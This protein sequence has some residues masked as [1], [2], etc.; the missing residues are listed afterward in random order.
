MERSGVSPHDDDDDEKRRLQQSPSTSPKERPNLSSLEIPA[1][2]LETDDPTFTT[3]TRTKS[4]NSDSATREP[5][6]PRPNSATSALRNLLLPLPLPQ[7]SLS[8]T[9]RSK[10]RARPGGG[11]DDDDDAAEA[12]NTFL[13]I[14]APPLADPPHSVVSHL[15]SLFDS[16]FEVDCVHF[17]F[18]AEFLYPFFFLRKLDV[19]HHIRRSL[20]VPLDIK[21]A[22]LGRTDSGALFRVISAASPRST[23]PGAD[24]PS[25]ATW[26]DIAIHDEINAGEE[27]IPEEEAVCRICLVELA[28]GGDTLKLECSCKGELAL[29]H[30]ACA[31]KWF[32]IKGNRTC[33]VCKQ[34]VQN[35]PVTLLKIQN[36][37]TVRRRRRRPAR[38]QAEVPQNEIVRYS[39]AYKP[40]RR[41]VTKVMSFYMVWQ[42]VPVLVVVSMLAYFCFLEQML[43]SEFGPRALAMSLPFACVLGLLSS[44]IASNMVSRSYMWA[45]ASFQF[46]VVILF[47]HI[48]YAVLNLNA[49]MS[50]IL[51]S[52]TGLGMVVGMNSLIVECLRWRSMQRL[53]LASSHLQ[54]NG[55]MQLQQQQQQQRQQSVE[56][57]S[58]RHIDSSRQQEEVV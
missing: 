27:D 48:F 19:H 12:E 53:P 3:T 29:A 18:L 32:S 38:Q 54:V 47:A 31:V 37:R 11:D 30:Q 17:A 22:H 6:P 43:V 44:M 7:R 10:S 14:P 4:W 2:S 55:T 56:D 50:V 49:V 42:D 26:G 46:A 35:L 41:K 23:I 51:S 40:Q 5:L 9:F 33:D 13:L 1:R 57:S 28:E 52:L 16:Q 34:E 45:Y 8:L 39:S 15:F 58:V 24:F 21:P 36:P 25:A 20:S